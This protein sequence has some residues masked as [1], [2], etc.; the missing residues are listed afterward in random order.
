MK[1]YVFALM[2][3]TVLFFALVALATFLAGPA[4]ADDVVMSPIPSSVTEQEGQTMTLNFTITNTS[5]TDSVQGSFT[6]FGSLT[7]IGDS[8]DA[9]FFS[10][11][12]GSCPPAT[13][14]PG[15]SCTISTTWLGGGLG[16]TGIGSETDDDSG[17]DQ[18]SMVFSY[19]IVVPGAGCLTTN[20]T[21]VG[22]LYS[23]SDT[24]NFTVTDPVPTANAPEP[25]AGLLLGAGF[26][27]LAG[28]FRLKRQTAY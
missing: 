2:S 13:L 17:T 10:F 23:A 25:S 18:M 9:P 19:C 6:L 11:V 7:I 28:Y 21:P 14:G 5:A 26:V 20:G 3:L 24:F 16:E 4:Y 15:D 8:S 12:P 22:L 27:L 1:K